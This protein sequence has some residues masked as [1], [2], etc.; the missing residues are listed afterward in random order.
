MFRKDLQ[1]RI[2]EI[3]GFKKTTYDDPSDKFEQDTAFIE[4]TECKPRISSDKGGRETAMVSGSITV[5]SQGN[6]MPYGT[7]A[8]AIERAKADTVR[9]FFFFDIDTDIAN[10]PARKNNIHERR[11]S[12][13]FLYDSQYDPSKGHIEGITFT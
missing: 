2:E 13:S 4:V 10:S 3:F 11:T 7:M 8:K 6:K 1:K 12:F 9:P 5:Y